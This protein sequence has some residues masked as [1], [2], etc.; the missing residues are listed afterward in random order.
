MVAGFVVPQVQEGW[1]REVGR[2]YWGD[3]IVF[4]ALVLAVEAL[5]HQKGR[6]LQV[7]VIQLQNRLFS[8]S[9]S[10]NEHPLAKQ[11]GDGPSAHS[12]DDA[13]RLLT[14]PQ[15]VLPPTGQSVYRNLRSWRVGPPPVHLFSHQIWP[16][17]PTVNPS[18]HMHLSYRWRTQ[19]LE[20]NGSSRISRRARSRAEVSWLHAWRPSRAAG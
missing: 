13:V 17:Q 5:K 7:N 11:T 20:E 15:R 4:V 8:T 18:V 10:N 6:L 12:Q 9:D 1:L 2:C 16:L 14:H 19:V 3:L